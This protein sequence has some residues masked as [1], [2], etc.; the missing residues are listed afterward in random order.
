MAAVGGYPVAA[1]RAGLQGLLSDDE[2]CERRRTCGQH[3]GPPPGPRGRLQL[4]PDR[5]YDPFNQGSV[6][7]R[8]HLRGEGRSD[9]ARLKPHRGNCYGSTWMPWAVP[10][11]ST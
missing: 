10:T 1:P 3:R 8:L 2:F 5:I 7:E 4:L 9:T 11:M 6:G